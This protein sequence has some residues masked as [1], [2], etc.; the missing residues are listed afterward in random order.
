MR[1]LFANLCLV[2]VSC[3]VGLALCEVSLRLFYP[4]YRHLAD[5]RFRSDTV[6]IWAR[7]PN[8]RGWSSH[9]DTGLSHSLHHNNLAL[10]QHRDF[11]ATDLAAAINVGFFGDSFTENEGIAAQHSFTEPLDYL[12]NQNGGRFN[13]LNFGV[14]G[15]G[16][17]QS[18][19]HYEHFR[20][21]KDLDHV[22]Y[23]YHGNDLWNIYATGLFYLDDAGLLVWNEKIRSSGWVRLIRRLHTAYLAFDGSGRWSSFNEYLRRKFHA[24]YMNERWHVARSVFDN[25]RMDHDDAR[26]T[27]EILRQLIRRWKHLTELNGSTFSVVLLPNSPP[28]P[29]LIDLLDAEDVEVI[30]LY[31]YFGAVDPSRLRRLW[32]R[33]P[34]R[35]KNDGHWN[36]AGNRLG[37][38]CLYRALEEKM[39]IP[40]QSERK[41]QEALFRYY[42]AFEGET[43]G[44]PG[45]GSGD[46][47]AIREKYLA[48]DTSNPWK[49]AQ[50]EILEVERSRTSES[51][52]PISTYT[53]TEI[54]SST[55]RRNAGRRTR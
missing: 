50:E 30:D 1:N 22:F 12:L 21:A 2:F 13:V 17:G 43:P 10:R 20:Y 46:G 4:K 15:Y 16:T 39:D 9:P 45:G 5:A 37:A 47:A 36:E 42:A 7:T 31:A 23:V 26:N 35:F 27:L 6:R 32:H 41:L 28:Q 54:D 34:Y 40:R 3:V 52:L 18:L 29:F 53:S 8:A 49:D 44:R 25:G 51:S 48:L 19:L 55:S 33:S 11:S 38:V 24:Q 14:A